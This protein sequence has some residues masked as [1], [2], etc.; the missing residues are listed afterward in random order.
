M[1]KNLVHLIILLPHNY[2]LSRSGNREI[3]QV[4]L[5]KIFV[6]KIDIVRNV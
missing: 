5:H 3:T 1:R 4:K 6:R 2:Y